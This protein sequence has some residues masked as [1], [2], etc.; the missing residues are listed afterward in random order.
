LENNCVSLDTAK[1]LK[2]AGFPQKTFSVWEWADGIPVG[3]AYLV[4]PEIIKRYGLWGTQEVKATAAAPTAQEIADKLLKL[5]LTGLE[6]ISQH[7]NVWVVD[8]LQGE[9]SNMAEA[10]AAMW[11]ESQVVSRTLRN[12]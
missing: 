8:G 7:I 11:I 12:L 1:K 4:Q 2:A 10:L 3:E 6:L 5:R 9:Y